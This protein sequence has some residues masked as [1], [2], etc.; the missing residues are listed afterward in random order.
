MA[1]LKDSITPFVNVSPEIERKTI[2]LKNI[3]TAVVVLK[4]GP[5]DT[6]AP[7]HKHPHEQITYVAEGALLVFIGDEKHKLN[8]GDL[9]SVPSNIRHT[10]QI[11]SKTVRLIDSFTPV[12]EDFI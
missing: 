1:I 3:T 2:N 6:P 8:T 9:F 4:N 7:F 10:I 11:L 5:Q 12:R